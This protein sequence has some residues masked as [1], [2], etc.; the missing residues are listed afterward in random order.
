MAYQMR[1]LLVL[2]VRLF[3]I[4]YILLFTKLLNNVLFQLVGLR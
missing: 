3:S 2:T 1:S 4:H